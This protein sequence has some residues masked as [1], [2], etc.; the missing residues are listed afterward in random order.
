M[1]LPELI[2]CSDGNK[3]FAKIAIEAIIQSI[4]DALIEGDKVELRGFGSFRPRQRKKRIARNPKSGEI[5]NVPAKRVPVFKAGKELRMM[6]D[7]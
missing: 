2:Y 5:V 7:G 1:S 6:V 3:R 4:I